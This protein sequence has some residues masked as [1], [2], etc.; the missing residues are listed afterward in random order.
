M[1]M[2]TG[3]PFIT[4]DTSDATPQQPDV[5][6][7]RPEQQPQQ[8][9][10]QPWI[11]VECKKK[12]EDQPK[13]DQPRK[14]SGPP[15]DKVIQME[16]RWMLARKTDE[17]KPTSGYKPMRTRKSKPTHTGGSSAN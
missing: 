4:F 1:S 15:K 12:K 11:Q 9:E 13:E 2:S 7:Q 8:T 17:A 14:N 16:P 5:T 6:L 10:D 3:S